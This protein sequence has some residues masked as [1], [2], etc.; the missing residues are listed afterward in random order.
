[1]WRESLPDTDDCK[2]QTKR[3]QE[4]RGPS[5][6]KNEHVESEQPT[7]LLILRGGEG[8][9][10]KY[11][12]HAPG[13]DLCRIPAT[14][15]SNYRCATSHRHQVTIITL[16]FTF[17]VILRY[18]CLSSLNQ[19][20]CDLFYAMLGAVWLYWNIRLC[21][22]T[23]ICKSANSSYYCTRSYWRQPTTVRHRYCHLTSQ[24][25]TRSCPSNNSFSMLF[26]RSSVLDGTKLF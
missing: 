13:W 8:V 1:M 23:I 9:G 11:G 16:N 15:V 25:H 17:Q 7:R 5:T 26:A 24:C 22:C 12:D 14:Y 18:Q 20:W 19:F 4:E 6:R 10:N 2:L 3:M 21:C